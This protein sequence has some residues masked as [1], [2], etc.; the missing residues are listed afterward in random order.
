[1]QRLAFMI[2]DIWIGTMVLQLKQDKDNIATV[3]GMS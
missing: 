3:T 1:M 2:V